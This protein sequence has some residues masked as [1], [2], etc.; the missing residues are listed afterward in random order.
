MYIVYTCRRIFIFFFSTHSPGAYFAV[1][2]Y[3]YKRVYIRGYLRDLLRLLSTRL[4]TLKTCNICRSSETLL[5]PVFRIF[6]YFFFFFYKLRI[7][8]YIT[9]VY[10]YIYMFLIFLQFKSETFKNNKIT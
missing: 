5:L 4:V 8:K 10:I 6:I 1:C 9:A 7:Q 3:T 2:T